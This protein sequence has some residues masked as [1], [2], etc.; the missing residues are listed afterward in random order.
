MF[1]YGKFDR[2]TVYVS[3]SSKILMATFDAGSK[4]A[5]YNL[6]D[7]SL[8]AKGGCTNED[9]EELNLI[10]KCGRTH[11]ISTYKEDLKCRDTE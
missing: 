8:I 7:G 3:E 9:I 2:F 5:T 11:M 4:K 1:R 6:K 10:I